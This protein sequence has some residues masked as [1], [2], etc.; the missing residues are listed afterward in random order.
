MTPYPS[1]VDPSEVAYYE[2]WA[3]RWWDPTGPFWPLHRLNAVRSGFIRDTVCG[4][5][6]RD[7]KGPLPLAGLEVIDLGCGGGVLSEAV[8]RMGARVLGVDVT[9]KN[10]RIARQHAQKSGL[11]VHY[12][13]ATAETLAEEGHQYDVALNMEVV[14]HVA[15]LPGFMKAC[16]ALVRPGGLMFIATINRTP[17]SWLFAIVG[18]EYVLRWLPRGTHQWRRFRKPE[19]LGALICASGFQTLEKRG[20]W[21]D[22]VRRRFGL[23][24]YLGVNY[25]LVATRPPVPLPNSLTELGIPS[26]ERGESSNDER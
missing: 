24:G 19:E 7:A 15:D 11:A 9:P 10:I 22:P 26:G 8:A 20:V 23:Y 2:R 21:V 17:L 1:S 18:A 25:M 5:F 12:R 6:Q 4:H 16:C 14:E 3:A 13:A